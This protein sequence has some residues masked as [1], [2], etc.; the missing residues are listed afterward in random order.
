MGDE[1]R[2]YSPDAPGASE[3]E[4]NLSE[5]TFKLVQVS[6]D[7]RKTSWDKFSFKLPQAVRA[8]YHNDVVYGAEWRALIKDF[9]DRLLNCNPSKKH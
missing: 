1:I 8:M 2:P 5:Y 7:N 3:S 9:D 4:I 6:V